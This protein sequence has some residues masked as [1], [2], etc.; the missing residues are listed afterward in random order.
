IHMLLAFLL[1]L[2]VSG[3]LL[4]SIRPHNRALAGWLAALPPGVITAWQVAQIDPLSTGTIYNEQ[5]RWIP[6]LSLDL[7]F[8]LDGLSLLFGL[9]ITGIG[10]AVALYTHYYLEDEPRQGYFYFAL[11]AFMASML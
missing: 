3:L 1:L 9:I 8:R 7:T 6:G 4:W 5:Y 11:F 2:F 10:A